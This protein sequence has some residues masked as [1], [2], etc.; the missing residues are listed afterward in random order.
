MALLLWRDA[1]RST[2]VKVLTMVR[3]AISASLALALWV[4]PS[5]GT[6]GQGTIGD[7]FSHADRSLVSDNAAGHALLK[8]ADTQVALAIN[9]L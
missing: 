3:I 5:V 7:R 1:A 6:R 8:R 9:N 2:G 4:M